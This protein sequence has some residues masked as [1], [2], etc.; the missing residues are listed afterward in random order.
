MY[1]TH[2]SFRIFDRHRPFEFVIIGIDEQS[3]TM[4]TYTSQYFY[5][6]IYITDMIHWSRQFNMSKMTRAIV[7]LSSI[8]NICAAACSAH[9]FFLYW[10]HTRIID[11]SIYSTTSGESFIL[12]DTSSDF[13]SINCNF[14]GYRSSALQKYTSLKIS[15]ANKMPYYGIRWE[16]AELH[17][18]YR[19]QSTSWMR[20]I[21]VETTHH[22]LHNTY[23]FN[24]KPWLDSE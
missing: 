2:S 7:Y 3:R 20:K 4:K 18:L 13:N 9:I 6:F 5:H 21:Q 16:Y 24:T 23:Y 1:A 8:V 17:L 22:T 11:A 14:L 10:T 15:I 19:S 12:C